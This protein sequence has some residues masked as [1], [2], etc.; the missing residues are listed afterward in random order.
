MGG[1]VGEGRGSD[2]PGIST[3]T[4]GRGKE[5]GKRR[6]HEHRRHTGLLEQKVLR[7][8]KARTTAS[9]KE[10]IGL[11]NVV[12]R[13]GSTIRKS[14]P[15]E[16][17]GGGARKTGHKQ[18]ESIKRCTVSSLNPTSLNKIPE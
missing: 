15:W 10:T 6:C 1:A 11:L 16:R 5:R 17:Q 7:G 12:V 13:Y 14:E 8:K 2:P 9:K 4:S 3:R 18:T